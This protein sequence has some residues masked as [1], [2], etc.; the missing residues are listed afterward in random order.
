MSHNLKGRENK[1]TAI[2]Q[3]GD[4]GT[5]KKI[6]GGHRPGSTSEFGVCMTTTLLMTFCCCEWFCRRETTSRQRTSFC[7]KVKQKFSMS[8][9]T[10]SAHGAAMMH[11]RFNC[12]KAV[13]LWGS[14]SVW[15]FS[16]FPNKVTQLPSCMFGSDWSR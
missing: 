9:E 15:L 12:A 2:S 1:Y 13:S 14:C 11:S 8:T 16:G 6:R 5:R 7:L 4:Y 10:S 3:C